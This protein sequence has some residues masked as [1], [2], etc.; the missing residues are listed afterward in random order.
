MY[1]KVKELYLHQEE[2]WGMERGGEVGRITSG[3]RVRWRGRN[4]GSGTGGGS[5]SSDA[6]PLAVNE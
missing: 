1:Q 5:S 3:G 6:T 2:E 4:V